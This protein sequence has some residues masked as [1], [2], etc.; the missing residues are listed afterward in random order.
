MYSFNF[1]GFS[2]YTSIKLSN[3]EINRAY[4]ERAKTQNVGEAYAQF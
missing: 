2:N 1:G 4:A 3:S